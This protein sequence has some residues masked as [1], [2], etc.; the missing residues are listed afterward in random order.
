MNRSTT[1]SRGEL[2]LPRLGL[3]ALTWGS[4]SG[5]G[6]WTSS[7]LMYG[8][9][10]GPAEEKRAMELSLAAGV[11]LFDTAEMYG[12]GASE[13]RLGELAR[14]EQCLLATK[15]PPRGNS[16]AADFPE[17]LE[18]SLARLGRSSIDLYQHH[19]PSDRIS[20]P[21]M[22]DL[23]AGAVG[24]GKVRAVGVSNYSAE[25]MRIAYSALARHDIRLASNQ[26]EW[27]TL[28]KIYNGSP[29]SGAPA[30]CHE[31]VS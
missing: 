2:R 25:Q 11:T 24:E 18:A 12:N 27:S 22:M 31:T 21:Q 26:V 1:V 8:G 13:L 7:M 4:P 28:R 6:R 17:A 23:M 10:G 14:G 29:S 20:I 30:F 19:F 3:G 15:F 5:R 16:R 9:S